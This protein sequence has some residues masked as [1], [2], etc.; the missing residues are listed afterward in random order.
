IPLIFGWNPISNHKKV[1]LN[2]IKPVIE[3]R[4]YD[5]KRLGDTWVAPLD[6]LQYYLDDP[7]EAQDI[8]KQCNRNVL[9]FDDIASIVKLNSFVKKSLRCDSDIVTLP[10]KCISKSYYTFANG[11]KYQ[12][13]IFFS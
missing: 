8:N 4:P 10:H 2:R 1:I 3:K 6:A 7:K 13:V 12:V 11:Y 5:K 9:T